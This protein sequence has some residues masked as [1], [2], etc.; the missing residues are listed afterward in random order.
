MDQKSNLKIY[1]RKWNLTKKL[2]VRWV[3]NSKLRNFSS[4]N[5]L[6]R[7][8]S[9]WWATSLVSKDNLNK[10]DWYI[11]L[12]TI[13]NKKNSRNNLSD[14]FFIFYLVFFLKF[15]KNFFFYLIWNI[16]IKLVSFTRY[17]FIDQQRCFHSFNYNFFFD[18]KQKLFLDRCYKYAFTNG[19]KKN[20][21][22]INIISRGKYF[23]NIF[24]FKNKKINYIIADEQLSIWDVVEVYF[25]TLL[26]LIKLQNFLRKNKKIFYINN[27][28]CEKVLKPFLI[29]SFAGEIQNYILTGI[30]VG[31]FLKRKNIKYFINYGE[32]TP[33]FRPIYHF[34]RNS[35]KDTKI[36]TIQ[37]GNANTNLIY[38]YSDKSEFTSNFSNSGK[39]F[40]P[41]PDIYFTH[42]TQFDKTLNSYFKHSK[43]IGPLKYDYH[44]ISRKEKNFSKKNKRSKKNILICPSIGDHEIILDF[45]KFAGNYKHNFIL[46]PHP[47]YSE[48]VNKYLKTLKKKCNIFHYKNK[49]THD[50][51]KKSDL[52]ICGF[53]TIAQEAAILGVPSLRLLNLDKPY[54]HDTQDKIK[55]VFDKKTLKS[56]LN[57][58][59]FNIFLGDSKLIEKKFY[60]KLDN[61]AFNRFGKFLK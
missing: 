18:R 43:I 33:G 42:G 59:N 2:Y 19:I 10:K 20:F 6:I 23:Y 51:L 30:S 4:E 5:L 44:L 38:N 46:S 32:F 3:S 49:T 15:L 13:L 40:S 55:I 17:Q 56:I 41:C 60:N 29:S 24:K 48:Y 9:I 53:S 36:F 31:K 52:V 11:D 61:K 25:K 50:L 22:L 57:K 37:H 14:N 27:I 1:F 47:V 34:V 58:E 26:L 35:N 39:T 21:Y 45:L 54:F 12:N 28:N 7:G 8:L 16:S